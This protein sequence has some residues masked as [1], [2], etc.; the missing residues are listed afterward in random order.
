MVVLSKRL[1]EKLLESRAVGRVFDRLWRWRNRRSLPAFAPHPARPRELTIEVT[2]ICNAD[3]VFCGYQFQQRRKGVM[4]FELFREIVD[5]Y[6]AIGGGMI[7]LTPVVGDALVDPGLEDKVRYA[8]TRPEIGRISLITNGILLT[9]ARF[10]S[11]AAAGV[12]H[13]SISI[14]GLDRAEYERVYRVNRYDTVLA[15]LTAIAGSPFFRQVPIA[16]GIRSDTLRAWRRSPD[17]ARLAALGYTDHGATLLLDNWSGRIRTATLPGMMMVRPPRAKTTPCWM[18]YNST[19]VL[20][21]G[22]M[23]ACGCRDL[24]G[25]SELALGEIRNQ[26]LDAPWTDGRMETLRRRFRD[27]NLPDVCRDCRHYVPAIETAATNLPAG[28]QPV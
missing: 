22:R 5:K 1:L 24:D 7:E 2:N 26:S 14:S 21:D 17:L 10:E 16:L 27:G 13:L 18:L 3:C 28:G 19:T 12:T 4:P 6:V 9:R 8:R 20:A 11:L 23:T 15:N 25:T